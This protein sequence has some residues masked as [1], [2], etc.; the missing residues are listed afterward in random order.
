MNQGWGRKESKGWPSS[1]PV[2]S[3]TALA[4]ALL[5]AILCG[6]YRYVFVWT[7]LERHYLREYFLTSLMTRLGAKTDQQD[8]LVV[9]TRKGNRLAVDGDVVSIKTESGETSFTL[10]K[11]AV[12]EGG[13]RLKWQRQQY[14]NVELHALLGT[15]I[16]DGQTFADLASRPLWW[17]WQ[18]SYWLYFLLALRMPRKC[19]RC[20]TGDA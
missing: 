8:I 9:V 14:D 19:G 17:G 10:S 4:I 7:P 18:C 11:E 13:L 6:Y 2:Y 12:K 20:A 16:Y 1:A 3:I 15:W 5:I